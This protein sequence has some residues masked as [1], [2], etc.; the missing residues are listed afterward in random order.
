MRVVNCLGHRSAQV[1][2]GRRV[3][4]AGPRLVFD[5]PRQPLMSADDSVAVRKNLGSSAMTD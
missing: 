5:R 3:A 1:I 2:E 4:E